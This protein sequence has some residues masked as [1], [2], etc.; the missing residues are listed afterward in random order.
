MGGGGGAVRGESLD[1]SVLYREG[2]WHHQLSQWGCVLV[3]GRWEAGLPYT[4]NLQE[5]LSCSPPPE[6]S[7]GG[8]A[9]EQA[10]RRNGKR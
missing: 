3:A 1:Q 6:G 4:C 5:P 9:E 7:M 8:F 10:G 2:D